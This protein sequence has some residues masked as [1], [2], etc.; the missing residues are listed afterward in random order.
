MGILWQT[1][2]L[3]SWKPIFRWIPIESIIKDNQEDY[4][5][6]ITLSTS[7]GKVQPF[8]YIYAWRY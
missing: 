1:A 6:S 7:E 5:K 8:Y 2:L 3:G 4:Y